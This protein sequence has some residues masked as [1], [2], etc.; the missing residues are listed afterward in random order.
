[1]FKFQNPYGEERFLVKYQIPLDQ[2][3]AAQGPAREPTLLYDRQRALHRFIYP[4]ENGYDDL[5]RVAERQSLPKIYFW[6]QVEGVGV[7]I[8]VNVLP[9]QNQSW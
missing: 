2:W 5:N 4:Y 3:F 1:M 8:F 9:D 7:R 6:A